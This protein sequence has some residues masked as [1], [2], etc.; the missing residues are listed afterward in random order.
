MW[1]VGRDDDCKVARWTSTDAGRSWSQSI[2]SGGSWYLAPSPTQRA[3]FAPGGRR[4][5]PCVP[6]GISTIDAGVVRLLCEDGKILGTSDGGDS[7]VTLGRLD[8]AVSIRFT[9]PG[10]GV[11]LAAQDGC[12]A[13]VMETSDGGTSWSRQTC[14][15]GTEPL[16]VGAEGD[17][18]A[19][20]VGDQFDSEHRRRHDVAAATLTRPRL[21]G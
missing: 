10:D 19:A 21:T 17:I 20:Q 18:V 5:T 2:G 13:A 7:W 14:L 11:A 16:A 9:S 1:L 15:A 8:G 12:P 4:P 6:T 3:V